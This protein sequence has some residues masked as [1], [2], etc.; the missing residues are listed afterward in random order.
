M[1]R[2]FNHLGPEKIRNL[3]K[4][5]TISAPIK[6]PTEREICEVCALTKM[7]NRIPKTLSEHKDHKLALIQFDIA[8]PFPKTI[9]GN[10][11]FLLIIDN[12]TRKN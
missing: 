5:T 12:Y 6:I 10:R 11:Y 7:K 4:V 3:H 8:G 2:R 9:R 1:H